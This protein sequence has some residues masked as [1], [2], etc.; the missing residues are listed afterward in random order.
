MFDLTLSFD[1]GPTADVTPLVLDVLARRGIKSTFFV[2]GEKVAVPEN[3]A[4]A[5]RAHAEG[6]WIGNHTWSHSLPFG[7]MR[8][9]AAIVEF[10]RMQAAIGTLV[11]PH[12]FFRPYGQGGNLDRRLLSWRVLDHLA[13]ARATIVLW[14]AL[15]RDWQDPDGWV[16][17]AL[18]Q[19]AAIPWSLMVLHDLPT[20]A[21][22]H[23]ERFLDAAAGEGMRFVQELPEACLPI[24]R[25][26]VV[27]PLDRLGG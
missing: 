3:R 27:R 13:Q 22:A 7:L 5:E 19:C 25:G 17:R 26:E 16:E 21:M 2:I 12:R 20:G 24:V 10:D 9:E 18:K 1:N 4:L 14:S 15:P 8:P 11:H 6:H 23:L